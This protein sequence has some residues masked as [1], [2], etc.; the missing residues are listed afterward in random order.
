V[1]YRLQY[2]CPE[3]FSYHIFISI[4]SFRLP[5]RGINF[6]LIK[7]RP[8]PT[9]SVKKQKCKCQ[10]HDMAGLSQFLGGGTTCCALN[11]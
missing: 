10:F 1:Y 7:L 5:R 2:R 11:D 9:G 4:K 3:Q 6:L 8:L